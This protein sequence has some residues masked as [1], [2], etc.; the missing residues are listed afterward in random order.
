M[1][2][3]KL[4]PDT[5][6]PYPGRHLQAP[7]ADEADLTVVKVTEPDGQS[8]HV[9]VPL[10]PTIADKWYLFSGHAKH[11]STVELPMLFATI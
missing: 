4:N 8:T 9:L 3:D 1:L 11:S 2:H 10:A 5:L 7:A 6:A